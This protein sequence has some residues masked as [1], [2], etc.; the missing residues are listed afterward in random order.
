[1]LPIHYNPEPDRCQWVTP[2]GQCTNEVLEGTK[3]CKTHSHGQDD[4]LKHYLIT[5]H[6]VK[7]SADRHNA[8]DQIKSLREEISLTRALIE[9]R[10]NMAHSEAEV[11]AS[12]GVLHTYLST[13]E[14][15]VASCHKMDQSLGNLLDKS[16]LITLAQQ[17][18]T[19]ISEELEDHP[20]R[21]EIIDKLTSKIIKTVTEA[22]N[23]K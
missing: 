11:M 18:V 22:G 17:L 3:F 15:L 21:D 1:M 12:M 20:R 23:E 4:G 19:I 16:D 7:E 10:L 8:V 5:N 9:T 13:V 14:K 2:T 6:L